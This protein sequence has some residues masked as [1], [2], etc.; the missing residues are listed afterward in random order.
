MNAKNDK[1]IMHGRD[2]EYLDKTEYLSYDQVVKDKV[3]FSYLL[4]Y[5]WENER[6][7]YLLSA[8]KKVM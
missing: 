1:I 3:E 6:E 8:Q 7:A 5:W 4:I 2:V